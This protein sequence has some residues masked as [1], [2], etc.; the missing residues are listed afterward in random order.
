MLRLSSPLREVSRVRT[1]LRQEE[2]LRAATIVATRSL[3]GF[4]VFLWLGWFLGLRELFLAFL[5]VGRI[6]HF[7]SAKS[8]FCQL[9]KPKTLET[10]TLN[11]PGRSSTSAEISQHRCLLL[12]ELLLLDR[13]GGTYERGE[14]VCF[15][16]LSRRAPNG[17]LLSKYGPFWGSC[18]TTEPCIFRLPKQGS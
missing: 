16:C 15:C 9:L 13:K 8:F 10:L 12:K 3:R 7:I 2:G 14:G 5:V 11:E 18:S 4:R 1:C 6:Q 17:F